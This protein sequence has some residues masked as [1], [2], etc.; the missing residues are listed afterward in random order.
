MTTADV[1]RPATASA[2][3]HSFRYAGSQSKTGTSLPSLFMVAAFVYLAHFNYDLIL[4]GGNQN[5]PSSP[6]LH[7]ENQ[8]IP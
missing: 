8:G 3:S 1:V 4:P 5:V 7:L 2:R 6:C